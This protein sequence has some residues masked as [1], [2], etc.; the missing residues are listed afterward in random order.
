MLRSVSGSVQFGDS[1]RQSPKHHA[2]DC[3]LRLR[4]AFAQDRR[5]SLLQTPDSPNSC[6][7][8]SAPLHRRQRTAPLAPLSLRSVPTPELRETG[9]KSLDC[10]ASCDCHESRQS[11]P[12]KRSQL[13]EPGTRYQVF[14]LCFV[15]ALSPLPACFHRGP[16]V[17]PSVD[18]SHWPPCS[19]VFSG[20]GR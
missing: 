17:V 19:A 10:H 20:E 5:L 18:S 15:F 9:R 11:R 13:K 7:F 14:F 4:P 8:L 16:G 1:P 6:R 12:L 3:D 2:A